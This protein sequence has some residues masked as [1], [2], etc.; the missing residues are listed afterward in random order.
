MNLNL[1]IPTAFV[2]AL[3][4]SG[5]FFILGRNLSLSRRAASAA[6]GILAVVVLPLVWVIQLKSLVPEPDIVASLVFLLC[7]LSISSIIYSVAAIRGNG[8]AH[9]LHLATLSVVW[10]NI[11]LGLML[12]YGT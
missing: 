10:A 12:V 3:A 5:W 1:F 4:S 9:L 6:H 8:W 7:G 2:I 11:A